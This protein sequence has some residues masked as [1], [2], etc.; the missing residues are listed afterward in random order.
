MNHVFP[1]PGYYAILSTDMVPLDHGELILSNDICFAG[2]SGGC[3]L[4]DT[5][6][7]VTAAHVMPQFTSPPD[8]VHEYWLRSLG[9]LIPPSCNATH[10][11]LGLRVNGSVF[12]CQGLSM[13][14]V[15]CMSSMLVPRLDHGSGL[16]YTLHC[17]CVLVSLSP[18]TF[19][20][21]R[22]FL[23]LPCRLLLS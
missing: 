9:I 15:C 6:Q 8:N 16:L 23:L 7:C 13:P 14:F 5:A 19:R 1:C 10:S 3:M 2:V 22:E 17:A 12:S 20:V 21:D 18:W 4:H 11:L